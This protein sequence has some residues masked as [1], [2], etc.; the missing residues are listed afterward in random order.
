VKL[1]EVEMKRTLEFMVRRADWWRLQ[2]GCRDGSA[3]GALCAGLHAYAQ[4]QAARLEGLQAVFAGIWAPYLSSLPSIWK[5]SLKAT[6]DV[7]NDDRF[8]DDSLDEARYEAVWT[9]KEVDGDFVD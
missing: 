8:S 4:K 2:A 6:E 3:P 9:D 7:A 5:P 1:L